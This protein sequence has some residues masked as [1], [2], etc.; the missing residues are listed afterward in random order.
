[1]LAFMDPQFTYHISLHEVGFGGNW[2]VGRTIRLSNIFKI[3][4]YHIKTF[5]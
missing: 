2:G 1:M 5:L 4:K 3:L